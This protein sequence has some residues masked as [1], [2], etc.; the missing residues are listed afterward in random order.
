MAD[1]GH[2]A[3]GPR[4]HFGFGRQGSPHPFGVYELKATKRLARAPEPRTAVGGALADGVLAQG[5]IDGAHEHDAAAVVADVVVEQQMAAGA[6]GADPEA[7]VALQAPPPLRTPGSSVARLE[8][9]HQLLRALLQRL[10]LLSP[11]ARSAIR[12]RRR[13]TGHAGIAKN[14]DQTIGE[15]AIWADVAAAAVLTH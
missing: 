11:R 3:G 2:P 8:C 7:G 12:L 13:E 9:C 6:V 5:G 14:T 10:H 1:R 15:V 4:F